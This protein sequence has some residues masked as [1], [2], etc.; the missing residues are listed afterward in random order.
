[1]YFTGDIRNGR[2]SLP[3]HFLSHKVHNMGGDGQVAIFIGMAAV[4]QV[5]PQV[6]VRDHEIIVIVKEVC[7]RFQGPPLPPRPH[8][9]KG[10]RPGGSGYP[11]H[12]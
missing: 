6:F 12:C 7:A 11:G 3:R 4:A 1:M 5:I 9:R 8:R 10:G 2:G